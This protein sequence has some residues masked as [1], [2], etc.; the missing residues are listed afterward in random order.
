MRY[1]PHPGRVKRSLEVKHQG[2]SYRIEFGV[3]LL[4]QVADHLP[5][6]LKESRFVVVTDRTVAGY[7]LDKAT[8]SLKKAGVTA[9]EPFVFAPG[10]RSKSLATYQRLLNHLCSVGMSRNDFIFA[11]GG[12]VAGD[13]AGF[14]AASFMRGIPFIQCPTSLLAQADSSIGG[15]TAINLPAGKN[16]VGAFH[17]PELVI[18]DPLTLDT[19]P[20]RHRWNGFAEIIKIALI[21]DEELFQFIEIVSSYI[22]DPTHVDEL[23]QI[24]FAAIRLKAEIVEEDEREK[25]IRTW[26]NLGHTFGHA[27]EKIVGYGKLL[28]GE[29]VGLGML[30]ACDMALERGICDPDLPERLEYLLYKSN[31]PTAIPGNITQA[32]LLKFMKLDKKSVSGRQRFV[33][34]V[35]PGEVRVVTERLSD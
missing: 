31:L 32:D 20:M 19:L 2:G 6:H 25:G 1:H 22:M 30:M 11:L 18:I 10:E 3:G 15:K 9:L 5:A 23:E 13:L 16:L 29:A 14:A 33:L 35:R 4:E 17:F 26:L 12:G 27:L 8:E 7:Y 28:H 34:P 21:R 24:I